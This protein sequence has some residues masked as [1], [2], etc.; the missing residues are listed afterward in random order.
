MSNLKKC[1]FCGGTQVQLVEYDQANASPLYYIWCPD[2]CFESGM[3]SKAVFITEKWN[4]RVED[5]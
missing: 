2:C 5:G 1:P 3:Y 4:R